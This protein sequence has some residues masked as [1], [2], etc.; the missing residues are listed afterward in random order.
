MKK[1]TKLL[2][3]SILLGTAGLSL[4]IDVNG[5][6]NLGTAKVG[7]QSTKTTEEEGKW[8]SVLED[9]VAENGDAYATRFACFLGEEQSC[10]PTTCPPPTTK[11]ALSGCKKP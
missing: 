6:M 8:Q 4:A 3:A 2:A 11:I 5:K 7:A 10:D 1:S 9:C